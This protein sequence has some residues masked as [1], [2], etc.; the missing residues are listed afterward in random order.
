MKKILLSLS[1]LVALTASAQGNRRIS[2]FADHI[3]DI[4]KQQKITFKEAAQ[5]VFALGCT[6]ADVSVNIDSEKLIGVPR[7]GKH[8]DAPIRLQSHGDPST[9][10]S[11]RNIWIRPL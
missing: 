3:G 11:F 10:I 6:G 8:G 4:A 5:K 2:V 9:P 1:L 7:T